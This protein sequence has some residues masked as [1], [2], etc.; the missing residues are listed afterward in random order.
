MVAGIQHHVAVE[1]DDLLHIAERH[2]QQDGHIA[3]DPFQ[4]PDVGHRSGQL[5]EAHAVTTHPAFGDLHTAAFTDDAAVTHP[6]V[7][8]AVALPVLGGAKDLF[9]EQP[10]HLGLER[11]VVD[12][13]GFGDL[14]H[15]LAIGQGALTPL[16]HPFR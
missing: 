11:A 3:G 2:V 10:V 15:H 4:V 9:A 12:S 1:V 13:L 5:D 6:L 7:L 8:A 16:H 14:T